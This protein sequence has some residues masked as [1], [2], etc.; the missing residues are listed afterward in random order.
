[1]RNKMGNIKNVQLIVYDFDGVLTDN[2][3]LF[4]EDGYENVF[5]NRSDGLAIAMIK[6]MGIDQII[7][8]TEANKVVKRRADKLGIPAIIGAKDKKEELLIYCDKNNISLKKV[9]Y[10]GNDINDLEVMKIAGYPI[11][12]SDA[13][14]KIKSISIIILSAR[15]GEGVARELLEYLI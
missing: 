2:K 3:V 15:G 10:I 1:M 5:V 14:K 6:K 4:R 11:C 13:F 9:I 8:S 12:P 7:L